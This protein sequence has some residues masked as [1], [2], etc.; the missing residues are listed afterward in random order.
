MASGEMIFAI[1]LVWLCFATLSRGLEG[2]RRLKD[3][4]KGGFK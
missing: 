3:D 1:L 4:V 2:A